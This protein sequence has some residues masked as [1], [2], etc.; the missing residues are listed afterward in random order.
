M[1]WKCCKNIVDVTLLYTYIS[2]GTTKVY[3]IFL[4]TLWNEF[5]LCPLPKDWPLKEHCIIARDW[6]RSMLK[7]TNLWRDKI[8]TIS[9]Q[10][11]GSLREHDKTWLLAW[12]NGFDNAWLW[13][14]WTPNVPLKRSPHFRADWGIWTSQAWWT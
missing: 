6:S 7:S 4:R 9:N 11:K 3:T 5:L 1:L 2:I 12:S 8:K 10:S 13:M 14:L